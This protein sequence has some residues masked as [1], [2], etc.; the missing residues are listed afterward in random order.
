MRPEALIKLTE[1]AVCFAFE[2]ARRLFNQSTVDFQLILNFR[3]NAFSI[4]SVI[5]GKITNRSSKLV[6]KFHLCCI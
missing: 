5:R 2:I 3:M 1:T 4:F 6:T